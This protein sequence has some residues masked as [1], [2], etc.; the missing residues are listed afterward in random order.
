[1]GKTFHSA[2]QAPTSDQPA[3]NG[4]TSAFGNA[5]PP[6]E[7]SPSRRSRW[8]Q[9]DIVQMPYDQPEQSLRPD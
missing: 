1:L 4:I 6:T 5:L 2:S 3:D 8:S 9:K 7:S